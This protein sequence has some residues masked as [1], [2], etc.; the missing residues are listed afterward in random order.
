MSQMLEHI[1]LANGISPVDGSGFKPLDEARTIEA[2]EFYKAIA[3][4]SP[5]GEL[6]W[7]QTRDVY[8]QGSAAMTIWSPFILDELAGL[9]DSNPPLLDG[10]PQSR[11]LAAATGIVTNFAGPSNPDGAAW[12]DARYLGITA[13]ADIDEAQQFVQYAMD[14]GYLQ[15]LA[16]A[17]EGKFPVRRGNADDP[18]AFIQGWSQLDVGVDRKAP[19]GELYEASMIDEIVA[20]LDVG[21]RWG[22]AEG[23]L[24]LASK[25]NNSRSINRVFRAYF[26]GEMDAAEAVA[27]L[28]EELADIN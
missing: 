1:L 14:E 10:D 2:L 28:N 22:V 7:Q 9:R 27:A 18:K 8:F 20:G 5:P 25:M 24:A 23:Q 21:Q 19:L 15:T 16:I 12:A 11:A 26:D 3:E 13:D 17:P 4:A 6:Y